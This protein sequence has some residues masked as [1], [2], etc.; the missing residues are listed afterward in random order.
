MECKNETFSTV[1]YALTGQCLGGHGK[2]AVF[3]LYM[4][5]WYTIATASPRSLQPNFILK[6]E[7]N[8]IP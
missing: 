8:S 2:E 4:Q 6:R 7:I 3:T 5:V 1:D